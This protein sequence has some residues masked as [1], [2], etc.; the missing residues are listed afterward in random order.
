MS[1]VKIPATITITRPSRSDG[2]DIMQIEV[3]DR[4]SRLKVMSLEI[5]PADLMLAL[6]ARADQP[7][8]SCEVNLSPHIGKRKV[9]EPRT[10]IVDGDLQWKLGRAGLEAWV[11]DN[12]QEP[13]WFVSAS[14][15]SRDSIKRTPDGKSLLT[16][17]V[18]RFEEIE[19]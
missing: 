10:V 18:Y 11:R 12:C 16:Y 6:T 4:A 5:E 19:Q 7:T 2:K 1:M 9:T 13:G 14:L 17:S 3:R 15:G 8:T